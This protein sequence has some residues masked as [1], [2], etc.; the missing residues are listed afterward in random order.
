MLTAV[1]IG[2]FHGINPA[3][4]WLFAVF[5]ALHRRQRAQLFRSLLP[6]AAG[7]GLSVALVVAVIAAAQSTL[8][9]QAVRY[10]SAAAVLGFGLYRLARYYRHLRWA[11]LNVSHRDLAVWSFLGATAHGSGLMLAPLVLGLPGG[12]RA[13]LLVLVHTA[14]MLAAMAATAV[15]VHDR[16]GIA[17]LRR[18]WLNFDLVWAVALVLAGGLSFLAAWSHTHA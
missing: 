11:S 5:L 1:L 4:G 14:A 12:S 8:P 6:I 9:V 3:M 2:A 18:F 10:A 17:S 15:L 13:A 7:H 16:F